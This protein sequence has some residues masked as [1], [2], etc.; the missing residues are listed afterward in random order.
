MLTLNFSN[1][2]KFTVSG[3]AHYLKSS[4]ALAAPANTATSVALFFA[5]QTS[6]TET[7]VQ[8]FN[9]CTTDPV[10]HSATLEN[11]PFGKGRSKLVFKVGYFLWHLESFKINLAPGSIQQYDIRRETMLFSRPRTA[12]VGYFQPRRAC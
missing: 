10:V 7:G 12:G 11:N 4:F 9:W 1:V 8:S 6:D 2:Q 5:Q 3:G